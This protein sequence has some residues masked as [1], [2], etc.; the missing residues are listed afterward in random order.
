MKSIPPVH[1]ITGLLTSNIYVIEDKDEIVL[2]DAG[3]P[4]D[5]RLIV[6]AIKSLGRSPVEISHILLTHFHPD[7]SGSAAA[8][9]R[10]SHA[11]VYAHEDDA[12]IIEGSESASMVYARGIIG[13]AVS[14]VPRV[15]SAFGRFPRVEVDV[16]VRDEEH[17]D[18]LGGIRVIQAPGHTP[19]SVAYYWEERGILFSGD[20]IINSYR[21]FTLPTPGFSTSMEEAR[22][23]ACKIVDIVEKGGIWLF[24][25]GHGPMVDERTLE[26]LQAF[27]GRILRKQ[28]I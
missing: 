13:R 6:D 10:L 28:K 24:C 22:D 5:Y 26:R 19:G 17:L 27:R 14:L 3:I 25:P 15:V 7:H 9:R 1:K 20:A 23:S 18:I 12:K 2:F 11:K 21:F 16:K 4:Q 8:L